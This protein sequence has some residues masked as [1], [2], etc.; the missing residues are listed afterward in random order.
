MGQRAVKRIIFTHRNGIQRIVGVHDGPLPDA[1]SIPFEVAGEQI[2]F[3]NL[4]RV[5]NRAAFYREP[6]VPMTGRL[7]EFHPQQR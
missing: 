7:G 1:I 6:I 4:V 3:A 2:E 5:T